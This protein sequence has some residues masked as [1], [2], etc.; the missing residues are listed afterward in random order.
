MSNKNDKNNL[1]EATR[2]YSEDIESSLL[3]GEL[4]GFKKF[5]VNK[6]CDISTG[7]ILMEIHI[8]IKTN[9]IETLKKL[10]YLE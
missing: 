3:K 9:D 6:K 8:V 4:K 1:R 5:E 2:H 10:G 7:T